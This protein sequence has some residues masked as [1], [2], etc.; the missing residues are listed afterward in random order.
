MNNAMS[1]PHL[2]RRRRRLLLIPGTL[3]GL[4][5]LF[6]LAALLRGTW[7]DETP[8][9]PATVAEGPLTQVVRSPGGAKEVR[10]AIR[11]PFAVEEVWEAVTDYDNFGDICE[12]IHGAKI[13]HQPDGTCRLEA[14]VRS[15]L[16]GTVPFAVDLR[17]ERSLDRYV[18]S[19]DEPA[20]RVQVNRGRWELTPTGP[21][22][23]L[24]ALSLEVE[25]EGVPTF[26]LRNLSLGRLR[27]VVLGLERR[28]RAGLPLGSQW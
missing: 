22:E 16:P 27:D 20:G 15:G 12:C 14:R 25:V 11:L 9:D 6:V 28:L 1:D 2:P 7:A 5:L 8:R 17:H 19:W 24:V 26:V 21:Q 18:S 23:T 3:L 4:A 10:C 13:R